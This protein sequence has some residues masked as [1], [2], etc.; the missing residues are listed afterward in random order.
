[1]GV[2]SKEWMV[3]VAVKVVVVVVVV[4]VAQYSRNLKVLNIQD[5]KLKVVKNL[6]SR[7]LW[8][9]SKSSMSSFMDG[10]I[11][12]SFSSSKASSMMSLLLFF[13][14]QAARAVPDL[15]QTVLM[16]RKSSLDFE[17]NET[18]TGVVP[19]IW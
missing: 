3:T 4:K 7:R 15:K 6:G 10:L 17:I 13:L 14:V 1:M 5:S 2:H 19:K 16:K 11:L 18:N 9:S 12:I 8:S